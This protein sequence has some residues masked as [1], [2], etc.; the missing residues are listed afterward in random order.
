MYLKLP[1]MRLGLESQ[2]GSFLFYCGFIVWLRYPCPKMVC[3]LRSRV[4]LS[5]LCLERSANKMIYELVLVCR[6][7]ELDDL[8]KCV[9]LEEGS[10]GQVPLLFL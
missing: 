10:G 2:C 6:G 7:E 3:F 1:E 8:V 9:F 5:E 4:Q